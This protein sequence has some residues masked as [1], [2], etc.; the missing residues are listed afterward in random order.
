MPQQSSSED[1]MEADSPVSDIAPID[2]DKTETKP[3]K[4]TSL[5]TKPRP[6]GKR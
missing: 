6:P 2:I 1:S 3:V 5:P 4:P